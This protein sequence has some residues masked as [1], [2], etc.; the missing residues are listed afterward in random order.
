MEAAAWT[1]DSGPVID[2]LHLFDL[3]ALDILD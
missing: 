2:A 3:P 1:G